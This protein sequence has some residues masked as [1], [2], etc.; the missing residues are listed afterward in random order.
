M[1]TVS[2]RFV[3]VKDKSAEET[4]WTLLDQVFFT[5]F[6]ASVAERGEQ[7]DWI[8]DYNADNSVGVQW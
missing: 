1:V 6:R 2:G 7:Q 4:T 3:F 8:S 5:L